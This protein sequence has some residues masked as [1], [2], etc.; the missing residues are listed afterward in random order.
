MLR[1]AAFNVNG[2]RAAVR[3]GFGDWLTRARPDVVCLQ[4]VRAPLDLVPAFAGYHLS[5]HQGDRPGRD[6]VAVLSRQVPDAVRLGFGS[7]EFDGQGRYLEVDLDGLTVG[8]LY[9]PKGDVE[10]EK[11]EAKHRFMKEL[12]AHAGRS[13]R[14][15]RRNGREFLICGDYN[16]A[17][18]PED[19]KS[20][21]TNLKS[22][23]FLPHER[24]WLGELISAGGLV[25]VLRQLHPEQQGP[26]TWWSWR[27][28]AFDNDAG[29]RIDHQLASKGLAAKA[30]SGG[31]DR[32]ETYQERISDHS[33]VVVD[34]DL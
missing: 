31:V 9:L 32:A 8:S 2:I 34:Y 19:I 24:E 14:K 13:I 1:V 21:R 20:W 33:A 23:G 27:G 16:I 4:E 26:Y 7:K 10:G 6:G 5:Y 25:D 28:Q 12:S 30:I 17:H 22:V 18:A 15:A 3:R 11:L 29:W